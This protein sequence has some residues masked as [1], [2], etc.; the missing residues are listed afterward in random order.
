M[1]GTSTPPVAAM[2]QNGVFSLEQAR[3]AGYTPYRV[4]RLVRDGRWVVVL[5]SVYAESTSRLSTAS[6][7]WA[8]A[9]ATG[10]GMPV[11]HATAARLW[12]LVVPPDPEVHVIAPRDSRVRIRGLRTHRVAIDEREMTLVSG[13]LC[14]TLLRTTI[15]CLL[16]LPEEAGRGLLT[17]ALQRHVLDL[18]TVR[19]ALRQTGQRHGLARAWAV[20]RDVSGGAH[21]EAEVLAHRI[22][23]KSG[24]AGWSANVEVYDAMGLIGVVDVLFAAARLVLE[25]DGRAYHSDDAAFQ[26]DRS[27]QNRLVA[28]GFRVVRFTWEDLV[29]R[30]DE[31]AQVVRS[32][33]LAEGHDLDSGAA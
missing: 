28:A 13:V 12:N 22:L 1:R 16:W 29:R 8:A 24:I 15:D 18:D 26:R 20:L 30:P 7:A 19:T 10:A 11:S 4:R 25:I 9:L 6:L 17:D 5:G 23:R 14:T 33:L 2:A 32:L 3:R 21:S 31:V 27:R